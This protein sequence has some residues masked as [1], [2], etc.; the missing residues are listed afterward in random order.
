M[1][2]HRDRNGGVDACQLL[3]RD[4]VREGVAARASVLLRNRQSHEAEFG[5]LGDELVRE[6]T[7]EVELR[8]NGCNALARERARGVADELLLGSEVEVHAA[9]MLATRAYHR[10][11]GRGRLTTT[12]REREGS[13]RSWPACRSSSMDWRIV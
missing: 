8:G 5:E 7:L 11:V 3:D 12:D 6:A 1:R 9:G 2:G 13:P 10:C 4:R